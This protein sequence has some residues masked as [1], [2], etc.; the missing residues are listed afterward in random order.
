MQFIYLRSQDNRSLKGFTSPSSHIPTHR[1]IRIVAGS[2]R[3][4]FPD[5]EINLVADDIFLTTPGTRIIEFD[6]QQEIHLQI[7]NFSAPDHWMEKSHAKYPEEGRKKRLMKEIVEDMIFGSEGRRN[8]LLNVAIELFAESGRVDDGGNK[9]IQDIAHYIRQNPHLTYSV[10]DLAKKCGCSDSH[11]RAI[12]RKEMN[13]SPKLYI[14]KSKM[15]YAVRLMR[16]E[17]MMVKQ[18]AD[19]LGYND[20]YEF[21]KQFKTVYGK[22]PTKLVKRKPAKL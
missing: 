2:G 15:D 9:V 21:S 12:F 4:I 7:I 11:F 8:T 22:P 17:N 10:S 16:D 14:K 20:I 19:I 5:G 6:S 1:I 3:Y 13:V 18:V